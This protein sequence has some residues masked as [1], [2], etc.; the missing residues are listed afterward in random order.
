M[1]K[2]K[3]GKCE[4]ILEE[5]FNFCPK[6]GDPLTGVAENIKKEERRGAMLETVIA[7][8]NKIKDPASLTILN[9]LLNKIKP[10]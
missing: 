2:I 9:E 8:S 1:E 5:N 6:C 3:C 10:Q 4:Q 7:L